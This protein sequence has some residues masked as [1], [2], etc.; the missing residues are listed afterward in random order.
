MTDKHIENQIS[1]C[2]EQLEGNINLEESVVFSDEFRFCLRDD[3]RRVWVKRGVYNN[4]TF[5]NE[6]KYD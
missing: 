1:F 4:G 3:S 5:V 6:K 2:S